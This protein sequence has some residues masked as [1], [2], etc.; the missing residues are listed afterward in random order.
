MTKK[1]I[2]DKL[3]KLSPEQREFIIKEINK[4]AP[5]EKVKTQKEESLEKKTK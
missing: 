5:R 1:E 3:E 2:L 4:N